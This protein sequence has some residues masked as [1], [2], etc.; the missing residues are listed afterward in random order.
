MSGRNSSSKRPSKLRLWTNDDMEAAI[1]AVTQH[2]MGVNEASRRFHVPT[3]T[4]RDRISGRV[5]HGSTMGARPYLN[6]TEERT[7]KDF[8]FNA[9][10][11]GLGMTRG[12]AT[13]Y[14]EQ[15]AKEKGVLRKDKIT[16]CWF[17]SFHK[18]NPGV[19]LRKGDSMAAV[20]FRYTNPEEISKYYTLLYQT[21][22]IHNLIAEPWRIY[23]VDETGMPLDPRKP[24][25]IT[26]LGTKKVQVMGSGNKHQIT[27][28]ACA[29]QCHR[30]YYSTNDNI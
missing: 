23:N 3:T 14:A 15:V 20:R 29:M 4:L 8:L 7:L 5:T 28:V 25:I 12:H 18:R 2:E 13:M 21:L 10:D 19:A 11:I 16:H 22:T 6:K 1:K 17:E 26:R 9:S 30:A 27:V 24:R